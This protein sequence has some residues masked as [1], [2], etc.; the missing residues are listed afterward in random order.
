MR[1]ELP[2]LQAFLAVA[3][4]PRM[5]V[6][7]WD[8]GEGVSIRPS[9]EH[10]PLWSGSLCCTWDWEEPGME[11]WALAAVTGQRVGDLQGRS[12]RCAVMTFSL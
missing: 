1:V 4:P 8:L 10:A 7:A 2:G 5:S 9:Y 3:P 12:G 11:S 6:F